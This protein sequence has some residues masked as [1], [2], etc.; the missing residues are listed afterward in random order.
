L[1]YLW[2][3]QSLIS[4]TLRIK[5]LSE[6]IFDKNLDKFNQNEQLMNSLNA[7]R[8]PLNSETKPTEENKSLEK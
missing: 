8:A 2:C 1:W 5:K 4:R 6:S 7:G 3:V